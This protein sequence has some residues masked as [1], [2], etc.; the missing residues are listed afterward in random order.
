MS[1]AMLRKIHEDI[2]FLK[3]KVLD[4]DLKLESSRLEFEELSQKDIDFFTK[5]LDKTKNTDFW[6][7]RKK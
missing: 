5:A 1:E 4:I 6:T 2:E 7:P 3:K